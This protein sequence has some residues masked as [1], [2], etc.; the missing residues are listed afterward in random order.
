MTLGLAIDQ[1]RSARAERRAIVV[2]VAYD[3]VGLEAIVAAGEQTRQPVIAQ[4]G[5]PACRSQRA[6]SNTSRESLR[7]RLPR[8][9]IAGWSVGSNL[10]QPRNSC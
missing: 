4:V 1:L 2:A 6:G 7:P 3:I 9:N 10:D 5:P 8:G